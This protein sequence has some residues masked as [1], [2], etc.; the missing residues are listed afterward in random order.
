MKVKNVLVNWSLY[1]EEL[2]E[3]YEWKEDDDLEIIKE[4]IVYHCSKQNLIDLFNNIVT[5]EMDID[6]EFIAANEHFSIAIELDHKG[7]L[8][9][10]SVLTYD[11]RNEIN[12]KI[13]NI[14]LLPFTYTIQDYCENK[15]YGLTRSERLKKQYMLQKIELL[16]QYQPKKILSIYNQ[17]FYKNEIDPRTA[18]L[19]LNKQLKYGFIASHEY[20]YKLLYLI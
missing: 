1:D 18:Y 20:L 15:E 14:P 11:K 3:P 4:I 16:Y 5:I 19:Q 7:H 9:Y 2:L 13:K 6:R 17:I 8:K 12:K 10:R